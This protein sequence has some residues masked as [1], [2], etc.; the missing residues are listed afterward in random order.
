MIVEERKRN[1][2]AMSYAGNSLGLIGNIPRTVD[3][4]SG[5]EEKTVNIMV[6]GVFNRERWLIWDEWQCFPETSGFQC[7]I[8]K[9]R[10]TDKE[11]DA[12]Y[13]PDIVEVILFSKKFIFF[14]TINVV[15]YMNKHHKININQ[16][17]EK[18]Y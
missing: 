2:G 5:L 11:K 12:R 1:L 6:A 17:M 14:L 13:V 8:E 3:Y 4:G 10:L 15:Y 7:L 9:K 16:K 18:I